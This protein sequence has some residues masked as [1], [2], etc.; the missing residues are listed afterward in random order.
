VTQVTIRIASSRRRL[1]TQSQTRFAQHSAARSGHLAGKTKYFARMNQRERWRAV[2]RL[3]MAGLE[4]RPSTER[5]FSRRGGLVPEVE[6]SRF[7]D[8]F[9]VGAHEHRLTIALA[10]VRCS[11][12]EVEVHLA[13]NSC[14]GR[15]I[16]AAIRRLAHQFLEFRL[17]D[18]PQARRCSVEGRQR[19]LDHTS[20]P[21]HRHR[22]PVVRLPYG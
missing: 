19:C 21:H 10:G 13:R 18:H 14:R 6:S 11:W 3:V 5:L 2:A 8:A 17:P 15:T 1:E 7:G 12:S 22:V 20:S 16:P 9:V 4:P